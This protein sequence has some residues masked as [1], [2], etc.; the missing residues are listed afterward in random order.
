MASSIDRR[1]F[2]TSLA[3]AGL[4]ACSGVA[5][6]HDSSLPAARRMRSAATKTEIYPGMTGGLSVDP[7]TGDVYA[8]KTFPAT[9]LLLRSVTFDVTTGGFFRVWVVQDRAFHA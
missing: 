7:T 1:L 5:V 9:N 6:P 8:V 2:L 4:S 3:S